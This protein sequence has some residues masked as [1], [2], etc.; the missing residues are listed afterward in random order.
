MMEYQVVFEQPSMKVLE[1][2]FQA[3]FQGT[4]VVFALALGIMACLCLFDCRRVKPSACW[5]P[6]SSDPVRSRGRTREGRDGE[7]A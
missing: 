6:S 4:L 5:A 3:V 7:S 2:L 1:A